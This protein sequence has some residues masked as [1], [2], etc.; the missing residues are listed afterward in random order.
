[1]LRL[2][3]VARS[4]CV[5][6]PGPQV[7]MEVSSGTCDIFDFKMVQVFIVH[8]LYHVLSLFGI[9]NPNDQKGF[10]SGG[11]VGWQ[12]AENPKVFWPWDCED[13]SEDLVFS[14]C[15]GLQYFVA[16]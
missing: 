8:A 13:L 15:F 6:V 11:Q 14:L 5:Y 7:S 3:T 16:D 1:M 2:P 4:S 12:R 10:D 9:T